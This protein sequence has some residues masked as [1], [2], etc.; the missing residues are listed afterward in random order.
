MGPPDHNSDSLFGQAFTLP[1]LRGGRALL[2]GNAGDRLKCGTIEEV[3]FKES[4]VEGSSGAHMAPMLNV[5]I[6]AVTSLI[7]Y[8]M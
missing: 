3:K 8:L 4:A 5:V 7:A 6:F 1:A 2:I